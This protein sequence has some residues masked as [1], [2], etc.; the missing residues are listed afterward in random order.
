MS[1]YHPGSWNVAWW[2]APSAPPPRSPLTSIIRRSV[3]TILV[4]LLS[5]MLSDEITTGASSLSSPCF[6]SRRTDSL[7]LPH[8][9]AVK[10]TDAERR[11]LATKSHAWNITQP[12]FKTMF[13]DYATTAMKDLPNMSGAAPKPAGL[14]GEGKVPVRPSDTKRSVECADLKRTAG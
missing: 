14:Q 3:D 6:P 5:F 8:P 9:G 4:G 1:E 13:P 2:V 12:K 10:S 11:A 7:F